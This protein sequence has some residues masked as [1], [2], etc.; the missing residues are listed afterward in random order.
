MS[1]SN[2][3]ANAQNEKLNRINDLLNEIVDAHHKMQSLLSEAI[4]KSQAERGLKEI[5]NFLKPYG[6]E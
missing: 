2:A 4:I 5:E 1:D 6:E 3:W